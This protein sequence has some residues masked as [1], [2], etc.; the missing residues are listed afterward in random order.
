MKKSKEFGFTLLK[1]GLFFDV[2]SKEGLDESIKVLGRDYAI[3]GVKDASNGIIPSEF[4][5]LGG[6]FDGE[7]FYSDYVV[8]IATKEPIVFHKTVLKTIGWLYSQLSILIVED[9]I[10]SIVE[11]DKLPYLESLQEGIRVINERSVKLL[12][13][14]R[15]GWE[16]D[17]KDEGVIK[18]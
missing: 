12:N 10:P 13:Y 14:I 3:I 2:F 9:S 8:V 6:Y 17:Y 5:G 4:D 7:T 1:N 11:C 15:K 16:K 18:S